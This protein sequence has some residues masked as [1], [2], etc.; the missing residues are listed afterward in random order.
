MVVHVIIL[1]ALLLPPLYFAVIDTEGNVVEMR[2]VS[3]HPL[4]ISAALETVKQWKYEPT[5]DVRPPVEVPVHV[6]PRRPCILRF[7]SPQPVTPITA[8]ETAVAR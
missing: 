1:T 7:P 2:V 5:Y 3:S 4:L 6:T 8:T